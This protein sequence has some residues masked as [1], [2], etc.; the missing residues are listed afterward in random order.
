MAKMKCVKRM[1][2]RLG[3]GCGL[4]PRQWRVAPDRAR[5]LKR[6]FVDGEVSIF[7][8]GKNQANMSA[9]VW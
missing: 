6:S 5:A 3:T 4:R 8:E 7:S 9:P 2:E 1:V